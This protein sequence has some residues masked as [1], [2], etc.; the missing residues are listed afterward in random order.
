MT[1][2]RLAI[3]LAPLMWCVVFLV[4]S[5][6]GAQGRDCGDFATQ[7]AAQAALDADPSDPNGLDADA[8]GEACES[9]PAGGGAGRD[10]S[11]ADNQARDRTRGGV[12][13]LDCEDFR[14]REKAQAALDADPADPNR[15]DRD[16]DGAACEQLPGRGRDRSRAED[17]GARRRGPDLDCTD[18]AT[19]AEA[20]AEPSRDA[21]DPNNLDGDDDGVA[22]ERPVAHAARGARARVTQLPKTGTGA[23]V[24]GG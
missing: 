20:Q 4:P 5:A 19:R 2:A 22:C 13:D 18:F 16:A 23:A 17:G 24:Q 15:L 10:R 3:A 1:A 12:N 6:A 8:D 11:G 21:T 7:G 9:L 14:T